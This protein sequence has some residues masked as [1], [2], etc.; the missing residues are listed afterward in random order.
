MDEDRPQACISELN[1]NDK[2]NIAVI[3]SIDRSAAYP[4]LRDP[5]DIEAQEP[6]IDDEEFGEFFSASTDPFKQPI[7]SAPDEFSETQSLFNVATDTAVEFGTI[8][9]TGLVQPI[10]ARLDNP[11]RLIRQA[12]KTMERKWQILQDMRLARPQVKD[13]SSIVLDVPRP[14]TCL[15]ELAELASEAADTTEAIKQQQARQSAVPP[16]SLDWV[17]RPVSFATS[18]PTEVHRQLFRDLEDNVEAE[19]AAWNDSAS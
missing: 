12:G 3:S 7:Y 16:A 13:Q 1:E 9:G 6:N 19:R 18:V 14:K 5:L 8:S 10:L 4:T 15:E 11:T 17:M 2:V